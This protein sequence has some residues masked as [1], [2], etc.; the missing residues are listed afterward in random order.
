MLRKLLLAIYRGF[1]WTYERGTW[2]YDIM[3]G[4]IL[5]FIFLTPR[6]WFL[7]QSKPALP[8]EIVL[9]ESEPTYKVYQIPA[10]LLDVKAGGTVEQS[11][12]RV[13]SLY[14][15]KS[16]RVTRIQQQRDSAGKV[17]RYV[18]WVGE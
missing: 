3:V 10:A 17:I 13:L 8:S 18:V 16:I 7:A 11:A 5:A 12:Q 4:L 15:D 14:T 1:F 2:Q 9:L 6:G